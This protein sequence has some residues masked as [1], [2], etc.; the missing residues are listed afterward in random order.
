MLTGVGTVSNTRALLMAAWLLVP[1]FAAFGEEG[2]G[3]HARY[4]IGVFS[5]FR[6]GGNFE[7]AVTGETLDLDEGTSG[8]VVVRIPQTSRT[9]IEV[10]Y[11]EQS[12]RTEA[13]GLFTGDPIFDM[14]VRYLHI[15]GVY[16]LNDTL[17]RPYIMGTVGLTRFEPEGDSLETETRFSLGL[18]AGYLFP[19]TRN[20][21]VR[22]EARTVGTAFNSEGELFCTGG[23]CRITF[24][25]DVLWQAE[26]SLTFAVAF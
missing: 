9:F 8:G 20:S 17:N 10:L 14:K 26:V 19:I 11:A 12:T 15:G 23:R 2:N 7:D 5:G 6:S 18:G 22:F 16:E 21:N 3:G 25:S 13:G 24:D 1:P 4:D